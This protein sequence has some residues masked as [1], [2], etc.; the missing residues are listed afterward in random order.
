MDD[1][2]GF[3]D[4]GEDRLTIRSLFLFGDREA[5]DEILQGEKQ[6]I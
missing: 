2:E 4:V 3:G 1:L 5:E 6:N